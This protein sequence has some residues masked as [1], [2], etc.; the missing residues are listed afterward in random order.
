MLDAL[1]MAQA[2]WPF[3]SFSAAA[4]SL[5]MEET[6]SMPGATSS[7]TMELMGPF[8]M[9]LIFPLKI[10]RALI[11]MAI[12]IFKTVIFPTAGGGFRQNQFGS[13][14]PLARRAAGYHQTEL[15]AKLH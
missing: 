2:V 8:L 14:R 13:G 4:D 5:V 7:V 6:I 3:L 9:A 1:M 15:G 10:F 11:F 12:V